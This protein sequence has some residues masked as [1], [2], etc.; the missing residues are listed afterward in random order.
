MDLRL[1]QTRVDL[2]LDRNGALVVVLGDVVGILADELLVEQFLGALQPLLVVRTCASAA[3]SCAFTSEASSV[4]SFAPRGTACLP[5]SA[6]RAA[7]RRSP[8]G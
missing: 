5:E 7:A 8:A 1:R 2:F 3:A 4:T 6:G